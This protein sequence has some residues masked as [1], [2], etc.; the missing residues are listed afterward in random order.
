MK[1]LLSVVIV[2]F[3]TAKLTLQAVDSVRNSKGINLS[4]IEI[5][6]V[7]NGSLDGSDQEIEACLK[8]VEHTL[9]IKNQ[10][11]LGFSKANNIGL[12]VAS[13]DYVLLLNSDTIVDPDCLERV[14]AYLESHPDCGALSC[15][16]V[17]QNGELDHACKRGFPT[18]EAS[19]FYTLKFHK[20]WPKNVRFSRY[21]MA[22]LDEFE[23]G[24]V[25]ALSGAF[26]LMPKRV[27][28]QVGLLDE[29]FFMYGEDLDLCYRIK[30]AGYKVIY[31]AE[32]ET[33][34]L[35]G[36]SSRK[37]PL[38][39]VYEFYRAMI[40]FYNKHYRKRYSG[41]TTCVVYFGIG[42]LL[43]MACIRNFMKGFSR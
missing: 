42:A 25:D 36:Q 14:L 11:N 33:I 29:E 13:G 15:R 31:F 2:N 34:H 16:L 21:T 40:L 43:I 5:V 18:P 8:N 23:T 28:D 38:K 1:V 9:F 35:K 6:V 32:A 39:I 10:S 17:L 30:S 7:D 37:K 26:M 12:R 3:Q 41:L 24:E 22:D 27:L 19:L 4:E 20:I